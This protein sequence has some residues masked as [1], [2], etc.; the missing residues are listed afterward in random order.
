MTIK[1]ILGVFLIAAAIFIVAVFCFEYFPKDAFAFGIMVGGEKIGG[2]SQ[3]EAEEKIAEKTNESLEKNIVFKFTP[4]ETESLT[5]NN[6]EN[7][8]LKEIKAKDIGIS[9]N[10]K[11]SL[12]EPFLI[13]KKVSSGGLDEKFKVFFQNLKEKLSA[14]E[15]KYQFP[16]SVEITDESFDNFFTENFGQFETLPQNAEVLFN[17][18]TL[19]FEVKEPR[20]GALFSRE[21]IKE[22]IKKDT[23]FLKTNDLYLVLEKTS[24]EISKETAL[25]AASQ[26]KEIIESSPYFLLVGG[27]KIELPKKTLGVWFSFVPKKEDSQVLLSPALDEELIKNYLAEL[28]RSL[29]VEAQN[30]TLS[31]EGGVLK[32]VLPPKTG[33]ILKIEESAKEIQEKILAKENKISLFVEEVE[34][35]I[36]EEKIKELQIEKLIG[37]GTSNFSGSPKN[38]IHNI[39][40]GASQFNGVLVGPDTEFSFNQILGE[41]GPDQG[42]L[43]ELVIKNNK[44]VPEYGGG[45]CQVS[46]TMFRAAVNS[47]MEVTERTPHAYP[48][49]YYNP[50]GSDATVYQPSPDL[51]FKNNTGGWLLIQSKIEGNNLTFEFYGKDDGRQVIV[52]GPYQYDFKEDGS[53]KARLEQEVWKN[54]NLILKKTFLSSY[55]SPKLYPTEIPE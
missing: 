6:L 38:R 14:L 28:S 47:G 8:Y 7:V 23:A 5:G 12:E 50:Q 37:A 52:K 25:V 54:G 11:K 22:D 3:A 9:F 48:V 30:P 19:N 53:M 55:N 45:I 20:E 39:K 24:P 1:R 27:K 36:T 44:T 43:P 41:V 2:F 4:L 40:I 34:P 51:K 15:G 33:K 35:K 49:K 21:K 13:G 32:I 29:N 16:I 17:E 18:K 26:A 10:I 42:Y 46:T 31:F